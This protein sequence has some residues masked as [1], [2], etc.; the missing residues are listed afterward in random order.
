CIGKTNRVVARPEIPEE[1]YAIAVDGERLLL[2]GGEKS[3]P[4]TA[5]LAFLEEDLGVRWYAPAMR[6]GGW[7]P[8]SGALNAKRWGQGDVRVPQQPTLQATVVPRTAAPAFAIR[9]LSWKRSYNPWALRNR[10]NG[11]FASHHGQHSY[12]H[13]GFFVHTFHFLV[14]PKTHFETHPEYFSLV[15]GERRWKNAQICLANPEVAKVAAETVAKLLRGTPKSQHATKHLVSVSGMDWLGDCECD[16]CKALAKASGGY[17]GLQLAFVNRVAEQLAPEFPWVTLT[18]LAYRQSKQLP[19]PA[20]KAHPNV[21]VRFC[22]DFGAS[23]TWPYH[24]LYDTQIPD[25]AEQ[26][27]WFE[28][29]QAISPR[30]HLWIYPHQYRH[31]LAPMPSIRGV[32]DNLRYFHERQAESVYVQQSIYKDYGRE[33]MRYWVFSKLMWDPTRNVED[34]I[35]DFVWG[36]YGAAAPAVYEHEKLLWDHITKHADLSRA[37]DW[38]YAIHHEEMYRHGFIK[39][40]RAILDRAAAATDDGEIKQRIAMLKVGVVYVES[41]QLYT[42]MRDGEKPP[43]IPRYAAVIEELETACQELDIKGVGFFDGTRTIG[44]TDEWLAELRKVHERR[45]D[46]RFLPSKSWGVWSFRWD[47]ADQGIDE[48]WSLPDAGGK[49]QQVDVPAFLAQTPA[50]NAIGHGWYRT[51]V[52]PPASHAG[53]PVELQFGGVDEQAWVYVN[54]KLVGEHTLTSEFMVGKEVTVEDLWDRPFVLTIAPK[55]LKT[56]KNSLVVRIH[57]AAKNAGIHQPVRAYLPTAA[58]R[59]ACDGA[60]LSESFKNVKTGAIPSSWKRH[61]QERNGHAF[62][63]AE[64]KR[65]FTRGATLHLRDQRSH[66][67]VWSASDEAFPA[68]KQWAVQFDFRLTGGLTYKSTDE[69][70]FKAA[71]A[72]AMFALKKGDYRSPDYLPLLQLDNEET[73]GK[74]VTLLGL[75]KVLAKD[76]RAD[77]WHRL[78]VQRDGTNWR[79]YLDDKLVK[80]VLDRHPDYRGYAFGS[81]RDWQHVAQD[82]HYTG[83]KIGNF[84]PPQQQ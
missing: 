76:L 24:S 11:G 57:N 71:N 60:V 63:V 67:A 81:F 78:V 69:G 70:Q 25:L 65:Q 41:V 47:V 43:N 23:F 17:S 8:L 12:L 16:P 42:Q 55:Y 82:I 84:I 4:L 61:I 27:K 14:P 48:K 31:A 51:T 39:K 83:L 36:Y 45:F 34:L 9:L 20:M 50:G 40:A 77:Q 32:T 49:W 62:G 35:R 66:V 7:T 73:A 18:T 28:G 26:R 59:D 13:G 2:L 79:F 52:P 53:K 74:P 21:A 19:N 56:G 75:G 33:A 5:V 15:K 44:S 68:G 1:G 64:V 6:N 46:Q 38:I 58:F 80:T 3:G 30:M 29:W 72:G 10:I 37:R 54:G 22:T